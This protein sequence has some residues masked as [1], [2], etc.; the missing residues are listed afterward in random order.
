M[1][2]S[3]DIDT[4]FQ[5]TPEVVDDAYFKKTSETEGPG[6]RRTSVRR[7]SFAPEPRVA[8]ASTSDSVATEQTKSV[9]VE[10]GVTSS[11]SLVSVAHPLDDMSIL[12]E[13][14]PLCEEREENFIM[15]DSE[16][17][18]DRRMSLCP[19][20]R[21]T[22]EYVTR[23]QLS[24]NSNGNGKVEMSNGKVEMSSSN[25]NVK[26]EMSSSKVEV[27]NNGKVDVSEDVVMQGSEMGGNS[28][29]GGLG[30]LGGLE[31]D[32]EL[33]AAET[34]DEI[35]SGMLS[36]IVCAGESHTLVYDTVNV[37]EVLSKYES[38]RATASKRLRDVLAETGIRFLDNLS[39]TAR[40]ETL[41]KIRN[42]VLPEQIIYYREFMQAR[43]KAQ[44]DLAAVLAAEIERTR[45][46][47][48]VLE[49]EIDCS[50]LSALDSTQLASRLRQTKS[51]ARREGKS[52]WHAQRLAA[53]TVFASTMAQTEQQLAQ[54][55]AQLRSEEIRVKEAIAAVDLGGLAAEEAR[56][57]A[58]I[59]TSASTD[60]ASLAAETA[61]ENERLAQEKVQIAG[62]LAEQEAE[63]SAA[64]D[65][66]AQSLATANEAAAQTAAAVAA[67]EVG[68]SELLSAKEAV[69]RAEAVFGLNIQEI[70]HS[71]LVFTISDV[72]VTLIY[73]G[74]LVVDVSAVATGS[75]F[76]EFAAASVGSVPEAKD[77]NEAIP[78]IARY[79]LEMAAVEKEIAA[80]GVSLPYEAR[81][82]DAILTVRFQVGRGRSGSMGAVTAK[83]RAGSAVPD[84]STNIR[85]IALKTPR[86]GR[87]SQAVTAAVLAATRK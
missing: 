50:S 47:A 53:E 40:R 72:A 24:S 73:D 11:E 69:A 13:T 51:D 9:I 62:Q 33:V 80:A 35:V 21:R 38:T 2:K 49:R 76:K 71:R 34:V 81:I 42:K 39:L 45:H 1:R 52:L 65:L 84:L 60:E 44:N 68:R 4:Y 75:L 86:Y 64:A 85:G 6:E 25:S 58:A 27:S 79:L 26:V 57:L 3:Q 17:S 82:E 59:S 18:E 16:E 55:L 22:M 70:S 66:A 31:E 23:D 14:L 46:D 78:G 30:E 15:D 8:E 74:L 67:A 63:W 41:S 61:L 54:H 28:E 10:H 29:M 87:T 20:D 83:F 5:K 48:E 43:I 32:N 37:E 7:V 12:S 36:E 56:I 19:P 77:L